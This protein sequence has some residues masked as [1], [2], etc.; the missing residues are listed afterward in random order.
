MPATIDHDQARDLFLYAVNDSA[1]YARKVTPIIRALARHKARGTWDASRAVRAWRQLADEAD[2]RYA[3]EYGAKAAP[4][5]RD[6][7]AA[8]LADHYAEAVDE[9]ALGA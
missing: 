3:A 1:L 2:R 8:M 7:A 9:T 4:A 5:T 6:A